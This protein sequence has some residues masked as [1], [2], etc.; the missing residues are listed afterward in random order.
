VTDAAGRLAG[1]NVTVGG[2]LGMSHNQ[3]E[4]YPRIGDVLGFCTPQQAVDVA[5][6]VVV[7]QR[8]FGDRTDRKH[9]RLKYTIADRGL[10][11]FRAEVERRL[12]YALGEP[13]PFAFTGN[14]DRYGWTEGHDGRSHFT[15]FIQS[16]RVKDEPG[17][18]LR[19]ALR[20]IALVH[21]GDF[22]LT[23]N[24]NLIIAN[25]APVNRPRIEALLR[26]HRLDTA[27]D[28][29]GLK[30]NAMSCVALPT[31]GLALAESERYLP[32]AVAELE[33]EF[34]EAGLA[35][36]AVTF[37]VTG[38]PNGC[39]RPFLAEIG[40]VG[41]SPGKYNVYLGA[42][43]DGSRL[44]ALYRANVTDAEITGLLRPI[45][46][47]YAAERNPGEH[48][49]DFTVRAGYV[50]P[51]GRPQDFHEAKALA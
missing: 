20:E 39:G 4:T 10:A 14:G 28:A 13:R 37:R 27:N 16:G 46:R 30:L 32:D 36:D 48:F 23:A 47:R 50:N 8:D 45:I 19:S 15:L 34:A 49:G 44:N 6:K 38:C 51:T 12:G 26:R 21:Q 18:P 29:S 9:A 25:V 17:Y 24:Q 35:K 42:A 31:C 7:V 11:W 3:V 43:F 1:Y 2:G 33:R 41:K 22:R 40:L 5:E